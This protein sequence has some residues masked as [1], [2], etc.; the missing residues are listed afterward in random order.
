[1]SF[2][3]SIRAVIRGWTTYTGTSSRPEF[4]WF[5]LFAVLSTVVVLVVSAFIAAPFGD[6]G[7]EVATAVVFI[8]LV[9]LFVIGLSLTVRRLRDAGIAW[10]LIFLHLLP[11][12]GPA[13]L[14]IFAVLPSKVSAAVDLDHQVPPETEGDSAGVEDKVQSKLDRLSALRDQ[15]KISPEQFEVAKRKLLG[16]QSS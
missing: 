5:Q 15:G 8:Y 10:G 16:G 9:L 13:L 2:T 11:F 12:I 4:W 3:E 7:A 14:Y 1:M 6:P